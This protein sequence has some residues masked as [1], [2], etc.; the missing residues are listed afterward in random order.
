MKA[1]DLIGATALLMVSAP[2]MADNGQRFDFAAQRA[3][4]A[5]DGPE[6]NAGR[7]CFSGKRIAGANTANT[8]T[9]RTLYVQPAH[10][11]IYR[12]RLAQ[13]CAALAGAQHISLRSDG[14]DVICPGDSAQLIART[15]AGASQCRV[16][17]V[18]RVTSSEAAELSS[19]ALAK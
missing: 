11:G 1:L 8:A 10:G 9:G 3:A 14:S 15:S 18:R 12:M 4:Y 13:D 5:N 7:Q 17:D 19:S 2:A 6:P 16:V